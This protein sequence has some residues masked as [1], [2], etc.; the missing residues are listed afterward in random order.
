MPREKEGYRDMYTAICSH[1]PGR[2]A[3]TVDEA[4]KLLGVYRQTL[5]EEPTFP[6]KKVCGKWIIPL[7]EFARWMCVSVTH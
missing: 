3:C 5:V 2:E 6:K 1:F 7:S 4:A